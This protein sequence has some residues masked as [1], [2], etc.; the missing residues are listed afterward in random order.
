M[1]LMI[2]LWH[3]SHHEGHN[4]FQ[5]GQK[6]FLEGA[7]FFFFLIDSVVIAPLNELIIMR[8]CKMDFKNIW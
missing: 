6:Q 5:G 2:I 4:N 1:I 7:I 3:M 8:S